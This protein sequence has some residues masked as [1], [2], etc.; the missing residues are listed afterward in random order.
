MDG[1]GYERNEYG[2]LYDV[3]TGLLV[4]EYPGMAYNDEDYDNLDLLYP[5]GIHCADDM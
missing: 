1:R 2:K 3:E 5:G 4:K